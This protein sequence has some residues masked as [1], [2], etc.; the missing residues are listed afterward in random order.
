MTKQYIITVA[1]YWII[2]SKNCCLRP[3]KCSVKTKTTTKLKFIVNCIFGLTMP[4]T[5]HPEA[6]FK[7]S[8]LLELTIFHT[9][10][11]S[12]R[13]EVRSMFRVNT[14]KK[15]TKVSIILQSDRPIFYRRSILIQGYWKSHWIA[16]YECEVIMVLLYIIIKHDIH[17]IFVIRIF[18]QH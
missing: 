5:K 1:I 15:R 2:N 3:T 8:I 11:Y 17:C 6:F 13:N 12:K 4:K 10:L 14:R 9:A 7:K 18:V 16:E